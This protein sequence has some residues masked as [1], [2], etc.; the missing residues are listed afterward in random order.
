MDKVPRALLRSAA[1]GA[2]WIL[3]WLVYMV[4]MVL[5]A[6]DGL[7]SLILQPIV[8]AVSS[9]VFVG[10]ALLAGLVLRIQPIRRAWTAQCAAMLALLSLAVMCL[11]SKLGLTDVYTFPENGDRFTGLHPAAALSAYFL[12]L[13]SVANWPVR[14]RSN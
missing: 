12:L 2:A 3:G 6:Y 5:T 8:A 1:I 7:P 9:T 10:I 14:L 11:G 13:F 4:A